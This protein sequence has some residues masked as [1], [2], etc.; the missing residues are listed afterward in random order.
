MNQSKEQL[1]AFIKLKAKEIGF[2]EC[3][4]AKADQLIDDEIRFK[5]WLSE[6][7]NA[8]ME[9]ME[10]HF[11]KRVDPRLLEEGTKSV[12]S[13]L[14]N[15][16]PQ[17]LQP[18]GT[19]KVGKYSYG[20]DYH[21]VIKNK[22]H[23]FE[24]LIRQEIPEVHMRA[25][26][27]SAPVLEKSWAVKSGLGRVGKNTLLI[28]KTFGTFCL[29][30]EILIDIELN[31]D[32]PIENDLCGTCTKCLDACPTGAI[33]NLCV[34]NAGKCISYLNK[35][36]EP[37]PDEF[38]NKLNDWIWGC[39]ICQDVCPWN[40]KLKP[41]NISEFSPSEKLLSMSKE[42]WE[43]LTEQAFEEIFKKSYIKKGFQKIKRNIDFIRNKQ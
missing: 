3:G 18:E 9:Y 10:N 25:F 22:L 6:K 2:D 19:Y 8:G 24:D 11:H 33:N 21:K 30:A 20:E 7:K 13:L 41:N 32:L 43:N 15:Y 12:I 42:E 29:I 40:K 34:L 17:K 36:I 38:Q 35:R 28:N 5:N 27:D 1:T 16:Y 26:V 39:D 37:I 23:V 4:I 31:Y 14:L